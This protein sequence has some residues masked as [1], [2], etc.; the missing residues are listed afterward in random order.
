[1][2]QFTASQAQVQ[3]MR[4]QL[5]ENDRKTESL[6]HYTFQRSSDEDL[7]LF[8]NRFE[9]LYSFYRGLLPEVKSNYK[10][11]YNL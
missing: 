5:Q 2:A 6:K 11:I 7:N 10:E 3:K 9:N 4:D 8:M 1:M